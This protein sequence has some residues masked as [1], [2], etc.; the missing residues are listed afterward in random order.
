MKW[1]DFRRCL[2]PK[3]EVKGFDF[4]TT[5]DTTD[6]PAPD[7]CSMFAELNDP[8]ISRTLAAR[9]TQLQR[10]RQSESDEIASHS[11][12]ESPLITFSHFLPR[13]E[14]C[15]EKRFLTEQHLMKV[16][17]STILDTQI[18]ALRPDLHIVRIQHDPF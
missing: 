12:P 4:I 18:R 16:V 14:C 5:P 8:F 9:E 7:L 2:W 13:Q 17:G 3:T 15:P 6:G 11:A 1:S 10:D